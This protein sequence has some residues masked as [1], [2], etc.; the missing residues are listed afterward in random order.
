MFES[1]VSP[2]GGD[3]LFWSMSILVFNPATP[4]P[5]LSSFL[6]FLSL[7]SYGFIKLN[8]ILLVLF[9]AGLPVVIYLISSLEL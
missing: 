5:L 3:T 6:S 1:S 9:V 7:F 2:L 4:K 8:E